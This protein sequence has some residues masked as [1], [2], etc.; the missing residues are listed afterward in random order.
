[1]S[2][3]SITIWVPKSDKLSQIIR[4]MALIPDRKDIIIGATDV[5]LWN[6]LAY[7]LQSFTNAKTIELEGYSFER[8][9]LNVRRALCDLNASRTI[10]HIKDM[11]NSYDIIETPPFISPIARSLQ[12]WSPNT[13]YLNSTLYHY[14]DKPLMTFSYQEVLNRIG[15]TD[16]CNIVLDEQSRTK[17]ETMIDELLH[18]INDARSY[19]PKDDE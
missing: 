14:G 19:V 6:M 16:S 4:I 8:E 11:L 9:S 3:K 15:A 12:D 1:M 7:Y 2:S 5:S 13:R 17:A 10:E 18:L